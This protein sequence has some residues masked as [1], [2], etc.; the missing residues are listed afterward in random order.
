MDIKILA[1]LTPTNITNLEAVKAIVKQELPFL[2]DLTNEDRMKKRKLGTKSKG[3]VA[4]VY[5]GLSAHPEILPPTFDLEKFKQGMELM[6]QFPYIRMMFA[7]FVEQFDDTEMELG[8][9]LITET[10]YG[11]S[12]LKLAAK[13]N[14]SVKLLVDDISQVHKGKG[15]RKSMVKHEITPGTIIEVRNVA[16]QTLFINNGTTIL[17]LGPGSNLHG[18]AKN[19]PAI[20]VEPGNSAMIPKKWSTVEVTNLS[21]TMVGS[22]SVKVN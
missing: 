1:T 5:A 13:Y 16:V 12:L 4:D 22:F 21:T 19:L 15:K 11:Y 3:Y 9:E 6:A 8:H 20:Q 18:S 17:T 2:V 7:A 14:E 10:D